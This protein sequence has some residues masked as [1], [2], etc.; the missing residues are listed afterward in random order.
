MLFLAVFLAALPAIRYDFHGQVS[1]P[2]GSYDQT[3]KK[4]AL[5]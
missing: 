2:G 1:F 4:P 3:N 5:R